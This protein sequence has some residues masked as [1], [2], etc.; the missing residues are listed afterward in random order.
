MMNKMR[1]HRVI[2][3]F[4][5]ALS[6]KAMV[7]SALDKTMRHYFYEKPMLYPK[8]GPNTKNI[9]HFCFD[10]AIHQQVDANQG[11]LTVQIENR[12]KGKQLI[13]EKVWK[14]KSI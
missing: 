6:V 5:H 3:I 1:L 10:S 9:K 11:S 7:T 4:S 13:R 8:R 2:M 14:T 12:G